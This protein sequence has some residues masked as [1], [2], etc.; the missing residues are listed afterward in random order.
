MKVIRSGSTNGSCPISSRAYNTVVNCTVLYSRYCP[1]GRS[2]TYYWCW[3]TLRHNSWFDLCHCHLP[4][5]FTSL[6]FIII[7][8]HGSLGQEKSTYLEFIQNK[9]LRIPHCSLFTA[10]LLIAVQYCPVLYCTV[11][12][13]TVQ[14]STVL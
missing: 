14:C 11:V 8:A 5:V 12:H 7:T 13:C 3:W 1:I 9:R 4:K 2:R 6:P 10:G